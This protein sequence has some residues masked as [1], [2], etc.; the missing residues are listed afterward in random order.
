MSV[1]ETPVSG[2]EHLIESLWQDARREAE[3]ELLRA[4]LEAR[5]IMDESSELKQRE[6]DLAAEKALSEAAPQVSRILNQAYARVKDLI[7][8]GRYD[9]LDSCFEEVSAFIYGDPGVR[10]GFR[11]AFKHLLTL[12]MAALDG[13]KDIVVL[14]N[15][16]DIQNARKILHADGSTLKLVPDEQISGGVLLK[17]EDGSMVVDGTIMGRLTALREAPFVDLL[18]MISRAV[19][20]R[21]S[22]PEKP[23]ADQHGEIEK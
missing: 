15:P 17:T 14:L 22:I 4:R 7:L 9:F 18:K 1:N 8:R 2:R 20:E 12:T 19:D 16:D 23:R 10:K 21:P 3:Q 5:K 11:A 6:M 13:R